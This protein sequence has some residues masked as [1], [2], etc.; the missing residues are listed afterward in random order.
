MK[1]LSIRNV[2]NETA[3]LL[4]QKARMHN[5]SVNKIILE[6]LDNSLGVKKSKRT[7][8]Y[9]DLDNLAGTWTE[10]EL[11]D[12]EKNTETFSSIDRELWD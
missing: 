3:E 2:E 10:K 4:K 8:K 5:K 6:I 9:H 1:T 7:K 11:K 12:F